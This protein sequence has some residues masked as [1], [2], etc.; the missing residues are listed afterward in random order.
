MNSPRVGREHPVLLPGG[1]AWNADARL[2][3]DVL[4]SVWLA[5]ARTRDDTRYLV[6]TLTWQ[7]AAE[8]VGDCATTDDRGERMRILALPTYALDAVWACHA[9]LLQAA[10][11][12]GEGTRLARLLSDYLD[13]VHSTDLRSLST[14]WNKSSPH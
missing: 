4:E 3:G 6:P 1:P 9:A 11:H 8:L 10:D 12:G 14:P 7:I 5:A 13:A 2:V